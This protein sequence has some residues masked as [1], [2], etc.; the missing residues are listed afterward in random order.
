MPFTED[1]EA[2]CDAD[3]FGTQT[4]YTPQGAASSISVN[5]IFDNGY[6]EDLGM[7]GARPRLLCPHAKVPAVRRGDAFVINGVRYLVVTPEPDGTG[8]VNLV[9]ELA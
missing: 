1:L 2:F 5:G 9:L 4:A 6:R 8:M 7:E 3:E